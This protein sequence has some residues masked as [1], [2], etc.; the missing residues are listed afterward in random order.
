MNAEHIVLALIPSQS[1]SRILAA[2]VYRFIS[3]SNL[4]VKETGGV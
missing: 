2:N 3:C 4:H 1:V